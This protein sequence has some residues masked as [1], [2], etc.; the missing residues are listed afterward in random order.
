V[1]EFHRPFG[2]TKKPAC[3]ECA[4]KDV[5]KLIA[6]PSIQFKGEGFYKTDSRKE[7]EKPVKDTKSDK[8]AQTAPTAEK[9]E[10]GPKPGEKTQKE[11]KD[12]K[13]KAK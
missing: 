4:C 1:F 13:E 7:A 8:A 6:P 12:S 5:Q 11:Q 10:P 3:P 9:K 2:S